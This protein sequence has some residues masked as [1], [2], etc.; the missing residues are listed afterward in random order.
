MS[1]CFC[2]FLTL[3]FV[4]SVTVFLFRCDFVNFA[5]NERCRECNEVADRR[6]VAAVVKEGDWLCPE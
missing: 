5:R 2:K 6:P 3:G 1:V 4:F